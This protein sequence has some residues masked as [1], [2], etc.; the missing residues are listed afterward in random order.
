MKK[1]TEVRKT[2]TYGS[3]EGWGKALLFVFT[4]LF[5]QF[6]LVFLGCWLLPNCTL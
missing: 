4:L 2:T 3:G 6:V 1:V 5:G